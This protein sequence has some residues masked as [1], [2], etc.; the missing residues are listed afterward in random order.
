MYAEALAERRIFCSEKM[1]LKLGLVIMALAVFSGYNMPLDA[2]EAR[3]ILR[4]YIQENTMY[5]E[6][7]D[8]DLFLLQK[9]WDEDLK[10]KY[11]NQKITKVDDGVVYVPIV[12]YINSRRIKINVAEINRNINKNLEIIPQMC[13]EKMHSRAR[14]NNIAMLNGAILAVNGTYFKQDTGTPLG[15]LVINNEIISGPIY[16]RVGLGIGEDSFETSRISFKGE[17]KTKGK[18]IKIDNINQPRMLASNVLIYT[19]K[20][21]EKSPK[22]K[23]LSIHIAIKDDKVITKST[24]PI[25]I[26]IDGYV[27]SAPKDILADI[28]AGDKVKIDYSLSPRWNNIEHL[29]SGGPYLM[30]DGEIFLDVSSEKLNTI[31]GRN[32]RTAIG[33][34]KDNVLIMVTVDGRKEGST[35]VTLKELA[36]LMKQLGCY[37]AINLDGGSSTV[38]YVDGK[39]YTGSNIKTSVA[40]NNALVVRKKV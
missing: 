10:E 37:E 11:L 2:Y 24:N 19:S 16:E 17:I 8:D 35:G 9:K 27:I 28:N 30:K 38:M 15:A 4:G 29:I 33:Y 13:S 31:A 3:T 18:T 12:K 36:K 20:W 1:V 39:I 40:I 6:Q 21:G 25:F 14:I 5:K 22:T 23:T 26:P 32:P 34:T 7:S